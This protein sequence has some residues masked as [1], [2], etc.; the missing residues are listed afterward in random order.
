MC[1]FSE[2][3]S[4]GE[5]KKLEVKRNKTSDSFEP[6]WTEIF[7]EDLRKTFVEFAKVKTA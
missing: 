5:E 4:G 3:G 7:C 2:G 1:N 6:L